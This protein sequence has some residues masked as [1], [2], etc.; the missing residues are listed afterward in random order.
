LENRFKRDL[1]AA[2]NGAAD[3]GCGNQRK[4]MK[5]IVVIIVSLLLLLLS[6]FDDVLGAEGQGDGIEKEARSSETV[7]FTDYDKLEGAELVEMAQRVL[8]EAGFDPGPID[9]IYGPKTQK[10]VIEFQVNKNLQPTG[11]L[12]Q[13]TRYLLF[14]TF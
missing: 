12:D 4:T 10:A 7:E 3:A 2:V 8:K 13:R 6:F 1:F 5:E 9:G 14:W 11:E